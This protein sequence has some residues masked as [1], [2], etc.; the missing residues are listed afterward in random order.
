[1]LWTKIKQSL[2]REKSSSKNIHNIRIITILLYIV[3][4]FL[5]HFQFFQILEHL[6]R[7]WRRRGDRVQHFLFFAFLSFLFSVTVLAQW[8]VDAYVVP[9]FHFATEI[10]TKLMQQKMIFLL[11]YFFRRYIA[12][13]II[14]FFHSTCMIFVFWIH[15]VFSFHFNFPSRLLQRRPQLFP[16]SSAVNFRVAL[17]TEVTFA[18]LAMPSF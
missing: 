15:F 14:L 9:Y 4:Q 7:R 8:M 18:C 11:S 10:M 13:Y 16:C 3:T 12:L 1:M 5:H 2:I 6:H 17:K